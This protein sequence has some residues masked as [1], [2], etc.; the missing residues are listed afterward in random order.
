MPFID[1]RDRRQHARFLVPPMYTPISVRPVDSESYVWHGHA[2]DISEGGL[3]FEL[4]E[5]IQTGTSV[6]LRI[7]LPGR[8]LTAKRLLGPERLPVYAIGNVV[9]LDDEEPGP[10]R[11]AAVFTRFTRAGDRDRLLRRLA[12]GY[13]SLAA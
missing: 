2:Y 6:G 12:S 4:D 8:G 9:W 1:P 7:E 11:M 13:F 5:P 10:V 3:R